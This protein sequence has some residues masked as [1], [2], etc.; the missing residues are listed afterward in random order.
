MSAQITLKPHEHG[1]L[2]SFQVHSYIT[3]TGRWR[4]IFRTRLS[5]VPSFGGLSHSNLL[6]ALL[7]CTNRVL[8]SLS[9]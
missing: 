9:R 4:V 1:M 2:K 3:T 6:G 7:L 8:A 5:L